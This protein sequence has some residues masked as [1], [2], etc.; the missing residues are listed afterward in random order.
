MTDVQKESSRIWDGSTR[1]THWLITLAFGTSWW[2]AE[3]GEMQW[4][5]WSGYSMLGLVLFR[6]YWGFV[7]ASTARFAHF[8][9]GPRAFLSQARGF[10]SRTTAAT[11]GHNSMGGWSAIVMLSLL[12]LQCSIGLFVV[13]VD[14]IES[15]PLSDLVGFSIG[16][17]L[18]HLHRR[19]FNL[20]L[21]VVYLHVVV[22][23]FYQFYKRDSLIGAMVTG[24]KQ[25][26]V[27]A[28]SPIRFVSPWRALLGLVLAALLTIAV[29]TR[30]RF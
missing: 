3:S 17:S 12:L 14:V 15:G 29:V 20:L 8:V 26:A 21:T 7:G 2:T 5:R 9:R 6:V 13:D 16:R 27:G 4:H 22:I 19:V 23:L 25:L 28:A 18:A 11:I 1:I 24:R 30:L 10:F